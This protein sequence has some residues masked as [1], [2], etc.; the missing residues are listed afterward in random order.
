M[1]AYRV[2]SSSA[3]FWTSSK[4]LAAEMERNGTLLIPWMPWTALVL[5]AFCMVACSSKDVVRSQPWIGFFAMLNASMSTVA[6]VALLLYLR[7]P[8]L[9]LVFIMPFLVVSIGTDNMFLMLKSWRLAS[10]PNMEQSMSSA[11][12]NDSQR[13]RRSHSLCDSSAASAGVEEHV[14]AP[15]GFRFVDALTETAASLFITSL[16]DGLSF[17]I[18][19]V[20]DFYAVRVFCTYC[21]MAILFMF[22]FQVTFFNAVMVLCCR[23]EIAGRHSLFCYRVSQEA[24]ELDMPRSF[25]TTTLGESLARLVS[26][27]PAKVVIVAIYFLYLTA[28]INYALGI[29]RSR[30][31]A[32]LP[33]VGWLLAALPLGLDL[34]LLAPTGSYVAEELRAEERLFDDYGTFCFAVVHLQNRSLAQSTERRKLLA[35]YK[36]LSRGVLSPSNTRL[37]CKTFCSAFA[38]E[39]E[40]WLDEF[41]KLYQG[42]S[43]K[44]RDFSSALMTLA[45]S[46]PK[47]KSD[48]RFNTQGQVEATKMLL[49]IRSLGAANDKPRTELLRKIMRE[50]E[51]SGFVYDTSR[52]SG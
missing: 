18:G 1:A 36:Q 17:S 44:E 41:E 22:L 28:S 42:K 30:F 34:K 5:L 33:F 49:R 2:N 43:F 9:P 48:L 14:K 23:R 52:E 46:K 4:S 37:S 27:I 16:T 45:A 26:T 50:S 29:V 7:Y 8:F 12:E 20:S 39:G 21:A 15:R 31:S 32:H 47:F 38:S 19:S 35:L 6:A 13:L 3:V 24:K 11:T 51:F 40:F 25:M 10:E